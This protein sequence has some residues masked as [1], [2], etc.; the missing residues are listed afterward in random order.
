MTN[1]AKN[2]KSLRRAKKY[3]QGQVSLMTGIT[4]SSYSGYENSVAEPPLCMV[5]KLAEFYNISID[6]LIK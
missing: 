1:I 2:L 4:R 5:V 3:S 6:N